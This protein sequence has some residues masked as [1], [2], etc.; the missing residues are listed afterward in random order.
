MA[1]VSASVLKTI[2]TIFWILW[3][4]K[5]FFYIMKIKSNRGDLTDT[6]A[7][8]TPL[9]RMQYGQ[10]GHGLS[11]LWAPVIFFSKLN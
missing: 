1:R 9:A 4:M 7:K 8:T 2:L 10:K 5:R 3:S 11:Q 6:S